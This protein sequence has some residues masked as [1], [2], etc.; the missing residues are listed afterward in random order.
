M[1]DCSFKSNVSLLYRA[2][3]FCYR[4]LNTLNVHMVVSSRVSA[5]DLGP[6]S[7]DPA[8]SVIVNQLSLHSQSRSPDPGPGIRNMD[9]SSEES[10]DN[11]P[12]S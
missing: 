5:E 6:S 1:W 2:T 4:G 8:S 7:S 11:V 3:D 10:D 12:T 9:W